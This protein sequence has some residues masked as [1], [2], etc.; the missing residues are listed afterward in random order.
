MK[1]I[2]QLDNNKPTG[3]GAT[4]DD[5]LA[6][7][8]ADFFGGDKFETSFSP[9]DKALKLNPDHTWSWAQSIKPNSHAKSK[10]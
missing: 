3:K 2:Y 4:C 6:S 7:M 8:K 10:L 1:Y 9:P 5:Y